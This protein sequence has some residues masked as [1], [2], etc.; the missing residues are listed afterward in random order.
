MNRHLCIVWPFLV[1]ALGLTARAEPPG[2]LARPTP[3]QVA[4][5]DME[6]QMFVCL[7]P[8]TWQGREYDNHSTPPAQINPD[9]LDAEQWC[10]AARSFGAG[11]ILFVAKHTGGF[12]WWRTE[13][14]KYGVKET[15]FRE[16][17]GDVLA[18]VAAACRKHGLKLGIYVYPGDDQWGAVMGGGGKTRDPAKQEAYNR[19][20]RRQMTEVLTQYGPV[21][22]V[23][24][25]GS[26]VIEVGDILKKHCP[27]AMV[28]QGPHA[29]LRWVGNEAGYAPY[30]AWNGVRKKDAA[31]GIATA[32][33]GTPD[34]EVWMPLEVDTVLHDHFWFWKSN[35]AR[36]RRSLAKLMDCYYK[37]VGRG[38]VLL[39][40]SCPGPD[41]LIP[42]GDMAVYDAFGKEIAR[43][44]A[45]PLAETSGR[46]R[47]VELDLGRPTSVNHVIAMEDIVHGERVRA[48]RIEGLGGDGRW[49]TLFDGGL[50]IGH[51][52]IDRFPPATVSRVRLSVTQSAD[53]PLIRRLAAYSVEGAGGARSLV[54]AVWTFDEGAGPA[55][56]AS[57]AD[58]P[59]RLAGPVWAAGHAGKALD[60]RTRHDCAVLGNVAPGE[61]DFTLAAWV[62]PRSIPAGQARILAKER[63]NVGANQFRLYLHEGGRL[64]FAMT[65]ASASLPYPFITSPGSVPL[66]AWTHVAVTRRGADFT[67]YVNGQA[68]ARSRSPRVLNHENEEELRIG[69]CTAAAG[70]GAD[71]AFD[72][73]IDD[74]RIYAR[75]L[76]EA[77]L[78]D[79]ARLPDP[80]WKALERWTE[81]TFAADWKTW[82]VDLTPGIAA[83]G[84][85]ELD[86]RKTA[87][88]GEIEIRSVE[89]LIAGQP[90]AGRARPLD[91]SP[92][93]FIVYRMEQTSADSPSAA[94]VTA[95]FASGRSCAGQVRIRPR[96]QAERE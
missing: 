82:S 74:V 89:L 42:E 95:R 59:A 64:G 91:G 67:L 54:D 56:R 20:F 85:F 62:F 4:Y 23:W 29:T 81:S 26:C 76:S 49:T 15:P 21:H 79:P 70:D 65:D 39:L 43:R 78:A 1:A 2:P 16:G 80:L 13:T 12:C 25:D 32:A 34:G 28:F 87:G 14:S 53:T 31:T 88:P 38:A 58:W 41:G 73:L 10:R 9:K 90:I 46:G 51:K 60:F 27:E 72:G 8:C 57:G 75:A 52:K 50:S 92:G 22:E 94:R 17:K 84:E 71:Y 55:A 93:R 37:S 18:E 3:R 6:L 47:T 66:K 35:N 48:Y 30:P 7:D 11:Q 96:Q 61:R 36:C 40:N 63:I 33:H 69:A 5:Q 83:P 19:V 45:K 68:A 77:E 44:F 24:F 86:F